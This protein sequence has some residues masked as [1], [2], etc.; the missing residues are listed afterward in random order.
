VG[1]AGLEG[2]GM[3]RPIAAEG[4]INVSTP[5]GRAGAW[6]STAAHR[7]LRASRSMRCARRSCGLSVDGDDY[8]AVKTVSDHTDGG[9]GAG[10]ER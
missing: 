9:V 2:T 8:G 4:T 6:G 1:A 5:A 10:S 3:S 7:S